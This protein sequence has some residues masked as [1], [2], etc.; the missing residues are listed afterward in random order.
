[1]SEKEILSTLLT[2]PRETLNQLVAK[3]EHVF[4][5]NR[6]TGDVLLLPP[7]SRFPDRQLLAVYLLGRY[8]ASK[9]EL[10]PEDTL[11]IDELKKLSGLD[12]SS[13]SARLSELKKEGLVDSVERGRYRVAYA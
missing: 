5:I 3:S 1:M 9:L 8:F 2:D 6:E 11:T 4:R 10:V 7:K 13:I 12:E